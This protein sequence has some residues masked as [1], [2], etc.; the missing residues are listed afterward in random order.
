MMNHMIN[1]LSVILHL[2]YAKSGTPE[3]AHLDDWDMENDWTSYFG[4]CSLL[5]RQSK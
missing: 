1:V 2:A 3:N 5:F 4:P